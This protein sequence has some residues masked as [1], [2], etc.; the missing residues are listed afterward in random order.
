M[1]GRQNH[2]RRLRDNL[3]RLDRR[4]EDRPSAPFTRRLKD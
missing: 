3:L 1:G 2:F 4:M